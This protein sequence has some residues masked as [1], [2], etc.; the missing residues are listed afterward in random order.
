MQLQK[1]IFND[2]TIE[3]K[4]IQL[5]LKER[6]FSRDILDWFVDISFGKKLCLYDI[7]SIGFS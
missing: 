6:E 3:K 1:E 4:E 5:F 2:F 7:W